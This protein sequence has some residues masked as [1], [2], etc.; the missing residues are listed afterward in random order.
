MERDWL[1]EAEVAAE[2][3]FEQRTLAQWRYLGRGPA[4]TKAG[5]RVFYSRKV[6]EKWLAANTVR[7][8]GEAA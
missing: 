1:T 5:R 6:I 8:G 3:P 7:P 4:Y 2:Y